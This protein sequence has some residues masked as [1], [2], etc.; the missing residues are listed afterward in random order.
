M[1]F[2]GG[3]TG[4]IYRQFS[5]TIISSMLLSVMVALI[6]SPALCATLLRP[7]SHDG[8]ESRSLLA[9]F[10]RWFGRVNERYASRVGFVMTRRRLFW[11]TFLVLLLIVWGLFARLPTSFLPSED[12]GQIIVQYTLP[13][14]TTMSHTEA[15]ADKVKDYFLNDERNTID[16]VMT[17]VGFSFSGS[18]QNAGQ[19][20]A[21]LKP[22]ADRK[23]RENSS[24]A[25]A[26]RATKQLSAIRDAQIFVTTP[27]AIQGLGQTTGFS[28]KLLN[29]GGLSRERFL[30]LYTQLLR[31]A[32]KDPMLTAVRSGSLDDTPELKVDIDSEKL[33]VL[34]LT[35]ADADNVISS[36]WGSVYVNDFIDRGRVK[37]VYMQA[38]A[39]FRGLPD[40][41]DNWQVRN[42]STGEMV[43]FSAFASSHWEL[44]PSSLSRFN[45]LP[46]YEVQGQAAPGVSSGE[47]M[48]RMVELQQQLP[49]GTGYAWS[50]LSFEEQRSS[51][52]APLLY[53]LS[54]LVVFLCLAALYESWS[55]PFAVL[56]VIP[57]GI[58]G[59]VLAVS[60]RGL[61]NNIFFQ[62]GLLT[63][64]GLAAKNAILI[65]EFADQARRN[66]KS[67]FDAA[68]EA[69]R[70]RFRPILM[71]SLAFVA[72]AIPL[73]IA[74]GAGAQSRIAIG[75]A[76]VGGM[77][78]ATVLAIFYVPLFFL[79][80]N[81]LFSREK[82]DPETG[83]QEVT[84]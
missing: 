35:Q 53:G 74:S 16:Y 54:I 44:G 71:T 83:N 26:Q 12:Q 3:S 21:T 5:I 48:A 38:D 14:G 55:I 47:A 19:G 73:A 31:A 24:A 27:P 1:A 77:I 80:I 67:T 70:L 49:P 68:I 15:V 9:R 57:V 59:A 60:L 34:G 84:A 41:L 13:P 62:V 28:F 63:T 50:G 76:V 82:G 29:S 46:A 58:F 78:A 4:V 72:G 61:D 25:V 22:W 75:T 8:R 37:R 66:G 20:Y 65:V 32:G 79:T 64:M 69:A 36:A 18:G 30:E 42:R 81:R 11:G 7:K 52:Q 17:I 39:P 43:P 10:N 6:L 23:G 45:G 2:F 56:L 33:A 51:G 40:H